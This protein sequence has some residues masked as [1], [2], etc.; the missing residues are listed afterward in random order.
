M[1]NAALNGRL[2]RADQV[3]PGPAMLPREAVARGGWRNDRRLVRL[4]PERLDHGQ[5]LCLHCCMCDVGTRAIRMCHA[6]AADGGAWRRQCCQCLPER[7]GIT[8]IDP[9]LLL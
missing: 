7:T 2:T 5:S 3:H 8:I 4:Q 6:R 1:C 9:M